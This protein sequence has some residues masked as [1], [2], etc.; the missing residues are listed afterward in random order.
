MVLEVRT[1]VLCMVP[2]RF[3]TASSTSPYVG[4]YASLLFPLFFVLLEFESESD[5]LLGL[6]LRVSSK[7]LMVEEE[8]C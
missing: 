4:S 1:C 3:S 7:A 6:L 5:L 2:A 8:I